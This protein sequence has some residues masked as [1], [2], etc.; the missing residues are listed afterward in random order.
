[1]LNFLRKGANTFVV[2]LL[3]FLIAL[4][5]MVWGVGDYVNSQSQ[6]PLVEAKR[7]KIGPREFAVSYDNDFQ[8]LRQRFGG[9]LDKKTAETLGLKQRTL[10]AMINRNLMLAKSH[11]LRLT[12][13]TDTLR[14][15]IA[16]TPAFQN[17]T[18]FD[19]ERYELVL[20]NNGMNPKNYEQTLKTDLI[21]TQMQ[22]VMGTPVHVPN[23]MVDDLYDLENEKRSIEILTLPFAPLIQGVQPTEADLTA[24][25]EKNQER[26]RSPV[27]VRLNTIQL[28]TDSVRDAVT[29][30]DAEVDEYYTEHKEEYRQEEKRRARHILFKVGDGVTEAQA[31]EKANAAKSR[32]DKGEAFEAVAKELSEDVSAEQGGDLGLFAR[33]VMVQ[34]F[35]DQAFSQ[36][37]GTVSPPVISPFGVH[38]IQVVEIHPEQ[39][40][41]EQE[42]KTEIKGLLTEKKAVDIVYER[43]IVLEDQVFSGA[44][45]KTIAT[46]LNLRYREIDFFSRDDVA[47]LD[48]MEQNPK[49]LDAAFATQKGESSAV[50]E[51]SEGRFFV[52]HVVDRKEPQ[53]RPL[54]EVKD[55]VTK[56]YKQE[57]GV[58]MAQEQMNALLKE[59]AQG[60]PWEKVIS[61]QPDLKIATSEPFLR[62]GQTP[63]VNASFRAAT[64]KLTAETPIHNGVLETPDSLALIKLKAIEKS[65]PTKL[66]PEERQK[67]TADF[68]ENLGMEQLTAYLDGL[69]NAAGIRI[70]YKVLD[71]F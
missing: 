28:T 8:R 11:D 20:R 2:K 50:I 69:W 53:P 64:F 14:A 47:K 17:G 52:L 40:R 44:D 22:R 7:W 60:T 10:N 30:T 4:S 5:F 70:N 37:Q 26:Y 38:L 35:E 24:F 68:K 27:Q 36:A 55:L 1:M 59:L 9:S 48:A 12:V 71:Q 19:P 15:T 32:I 6:E 39:M 25:L 63:Q 66:S 33:G 34:A 18:Q 23:L 49:F 57:K 29:I 51:A 65:D 58:A 62:D 67:L 61:S 46:D 54:N 16:N 45:F 41:P 56:D 13:S 42:V 21:A 43:S 3:L 31:M